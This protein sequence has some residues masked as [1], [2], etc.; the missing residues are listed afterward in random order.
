MKL[1]DDFLNWDLL[2]LRSMYKSVLTQYNNLE[3]EDRKAL[4]RQHN[5]KIRELEDSHRRVK[6]ELYQE[7]GM[8]KREIAIR[9]NMIKFK[10]TKMIKLEVEYKE[11]TEEYYDSCQADPCYE[12]EPCDYE[13]IKEIIVCYA[14]KHDKYEKKLTYVAYNFVQKEIVRVNKIKVVEE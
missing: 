4:K 10:N 1:S 2:K 9:D 13:K 11:F 7:I 3:P 12:A 14:Y 5:I 8:L 6:D